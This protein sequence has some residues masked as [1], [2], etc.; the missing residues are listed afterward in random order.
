M[1][2]AA[3]HQLQY[4]ELVIPYEL[5]YARR[6]TLAISVEPDL[7]VTV[8]A[9]TGTDL[10]VIEERLRQR[11]PWILRQRRDLEQYLPTVPPRKFV[12]GETHRYLG[13]AYRLRIEERRPESVK[14]SG[15]FIL[16]NAADKS[17]PGR[18]ADLLDAWYRRQARRVFRERLREVLPRFVQAGITREPELEI[19]LLHARWGSCSHS[20]VVTLNLK[21]IQ[22]QK[23]YID[24]VI[25]HE[26]CHL[27]EH[28]HGKRF[29]ALMDKMMPDWRERR[30]ELNLVEV[31]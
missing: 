13:R 22:V 30:R 23:V 28:N 17:D 11:A 29:H 3:P 10:A 18:V 12:S 25:A 19:R 15:G 26:L 27:V 1:T 9:P 24:Y 5:A 20:G 16:I 21:L 8:A 4:G 6:K 7:R 31:W 2:D 14:V